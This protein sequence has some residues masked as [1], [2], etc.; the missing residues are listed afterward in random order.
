[1]KHVVGQAMEVNQA[2]REEEDEE[3]KQAEEQLKSLLAKEANN[4]KTTLLN[5][6]AAVQV[7]AARN[8]LLLKNMEQTLLDLKW[9][10]EQK[11]LKPGTSASTPTPVNSSDED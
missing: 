1:M 3:R 10:I 9:A 5:E 11:Q 6:I 4:I 8:H 7:H 2:I